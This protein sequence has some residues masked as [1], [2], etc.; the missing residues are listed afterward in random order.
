MKESSG[1][2]RV[3]DR[4]GG[5]EKE[6]ERGDVENNNILRSTAKPIGVIFILYLSH[7]SY[8]ILCIR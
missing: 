5:E 4:I 8:Y 3:E 6:R 2:N 1:R 7:S